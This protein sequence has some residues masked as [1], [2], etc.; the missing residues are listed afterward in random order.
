[1]N[2][3]IAPTTYGKA[4]MRPRDKTARLWDL[5][6]KNP[7]VSPVVLRGHEDLVTS[8]AISPG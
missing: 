2:M 3:P 4:V 6:A 1:M 5:S 8:V 7:V